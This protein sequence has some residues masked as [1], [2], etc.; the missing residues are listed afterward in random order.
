MDGLQPCHHEDSVAAHAVQL[1][2][3]ETQ[4]DARSL[5]WRWNHNLH[6]LWL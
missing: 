2:D 1:F 4:T 5:V 3:A 6:T